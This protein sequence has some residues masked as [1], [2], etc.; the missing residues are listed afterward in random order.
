MNNEDF[1]RIY[2]NYV[3]KEVC[4]ETINA[5][6]EIIKDPELSKNINDNTNQFDSKNLGRKDLSI[7]L[8]N[9]EYNKSEL[10][11]KYLYL[12]NDCVTKYV[13]D[14]GQLRN[15]PLS[16]R[17]NLKLQKTPPMG[18]YHI[19]HY[20]NGD[21]KEAYSRELVWII[22]LNDMPENEG[23][24][25]FLFQKRRIRPTVG[26]VLIWPAGMTHV[27]RGLT[28]YSQS[29]YILTGWYYKNHQ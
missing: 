18:G 12:L 4:D 26:T 2:N 7:F 19:W 17:Y 10:C 13:E 22:Y 20:E 24:T 8:E 27:H 25:E 15:I 1:I 29:K 5:F 6:E 28:V 3:P 21:R 23:E 11:T 16:N 14:F 9:P